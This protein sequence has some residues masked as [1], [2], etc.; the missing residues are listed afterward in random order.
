MQII[1]DF[2]GLAEFP[3]HAC[4]LPVKLFIN[5]MNQPL[6]IDQWVP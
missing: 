4:A 6:Y 5:F 3:I 2:D 1:R